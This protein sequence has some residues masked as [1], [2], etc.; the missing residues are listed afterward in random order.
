MS[1]VN[2]VLILG[3]VVRVKAL[4]RALKTGILYLEVKTGVV[5]PVL[6]KGQMFTATVTTSV[7]EDKRILVTGLLRM[8]DSDGLCVEAREI[9]FLAKEEA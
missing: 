2:T 9:K 3:N 6:A 7:L 5:V 4:D 8:S 1:E